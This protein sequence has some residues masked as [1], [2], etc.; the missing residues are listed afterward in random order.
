MLT[1][2]ND[3]PAMPTI[4]ERLTLRLA[5]VVCGSLGLL[6]LLSTQLGVAVRQVDVQLQDHAKAESDVLR[7][8]AI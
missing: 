3:G 1:R 5:C 7:K 4:Q 6:V 2:V 8:E